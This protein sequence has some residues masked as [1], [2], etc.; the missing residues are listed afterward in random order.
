MTVVENM[1]KSGCDTSK[2]RLPG[3]S[4]VVVASDVEQ[5]DVSIAEVTEISNRSMT[6]TKFEETLKEIDR[7]LSVDSGTLLTDGKNLRGTVSENSEKVYLLVAPNLVLNKPLS[8][9][10]FDSSKNVQRLVKNLSKPTPKNNEVSDLS[11]SSLEKGS[12]SRKGKRT[13]TRI[14]TKFTQFGGGEKLEDSGLKRKILDMF[15]LQTMKRKTSLK[16]HTFGRR[17][18]SCCYWLPDDDRAC[19]FFKWLDTSI[20]CTRGTATTLIVIAKF[21]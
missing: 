12:M 10:E 20:C 16:L 5:L 19:K 4:L 7:S 15:K 8:M 1:M 3:S 6:V 18:Y 13:W 17:F 21:N 9:K 14:S 11:I 2:S